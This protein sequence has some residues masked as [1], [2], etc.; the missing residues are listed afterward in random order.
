MVSLGV[1][2]R[3]MVIMRELYLWMLEPGPK[4]YAADIRLFCARRGG[5]AIVDFGLRYSQCSCGDLTCLRL[6]VCLRFD[7]ILMFP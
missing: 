3:H 5:G 1:A 7:S 4:R 2:L 6:I